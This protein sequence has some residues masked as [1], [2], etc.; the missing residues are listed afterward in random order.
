MLKRR[1]AQFLVPVFLCFAMQ[2]VVLAGSWALNPNTQDTMNSAAIFRVVVMRV[3]QSTYTTYEHSTV[4][5]TG[6]QTLAD[7]PMPGDTTYRHDV[8]GISVPGV[9]VKTV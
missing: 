8:A 2:S 1:G 9:S 6:P 3:D 7:T 4:G 5:Y